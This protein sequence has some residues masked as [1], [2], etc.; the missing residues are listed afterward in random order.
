MLSVMR[1][2]YVSAHSNLAKVST[3]PLGNGQLYVK[4][5]RIHVL[6]NNGK[7]VVINVIQ[8]FTQ[9]YEINYPFE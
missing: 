7:A 2:S 1:I 9:R 4:G 8:N 5:D 6:L 3:S